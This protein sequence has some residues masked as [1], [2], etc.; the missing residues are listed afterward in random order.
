MMEEEVMAINVGLV[1]GHGWVSAVD[2]SERGT[3]D[4]VPLFQ[5][6]FLCELSLCLSLCCKPPSTCR[7]L[8][9][10]LIKHYI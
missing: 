5:Y 6:A 8:A 1:L 4:D 2:Y 10:A 7:C 9:R 3:A